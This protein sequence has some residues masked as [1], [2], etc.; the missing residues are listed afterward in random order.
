MVLLGEGAE[1]GC[2]LGRQGEIMLGAALAGGGAGLVGGEFE[3]GGH[4]GE[5]RAPVGQVLFD[6]FRGQVAAL[7]R[8]EVAILQ[9]RQRKFFARIARREVFQQN[10]NGPAVEDDVVDGQQQDLVFVAEREELRPHQRAA[11]EVKRLAGGLEQPALGLGLR[12][13]QPCQVGHGQR[14]LQLRQHHLQRHALFGDED[15]AQRLV[16]REHA[17]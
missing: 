14:Q 10:V 12:V 9:G 2:Q 1:L 13:G 15:G 4:V 11:L 8:G 16:P 17:V 3:D 6:L 5:V 7:P